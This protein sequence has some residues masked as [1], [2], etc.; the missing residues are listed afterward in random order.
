MI[1]MKLKDNFTLRTVRKKILLVSKLA[2][3]PRRSHEE[4]PA[5]KLL[6][7]YKIPVVG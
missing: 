5:G 3:V 7:G 1:D 4:I 2:G 6:F